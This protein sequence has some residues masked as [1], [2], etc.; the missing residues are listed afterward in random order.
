MPTTEPA[1][2]D[3][4]E[5]AQP[6]TAEQLNAVLAEL[7]AIK[8]IVHRLAVPVDVLNS[9]AAA[10]RLSRSVKTIKRLHARGI[11]TDGRAPGNRKPGA[12]LVFLA[13]EIEVYRAEGE[14]GVRRLRDELGRG[15]PAVA[16]RAGKRRDGNRG[17]TRGTRGRA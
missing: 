9:A 13:D 16:S 2:A 1:T 5:A 8:R 11:F 17:G 7:H 10:E 6:A 3:A 4:R 14:A 12:D 15:G